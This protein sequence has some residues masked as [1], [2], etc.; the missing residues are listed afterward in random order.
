MKNSISLLLLLFSFAFTNSSFTVPSDDLSVLMEKDRNPP[1]WER[2]GTRKVSFKAER[3]EIMVTGQEGTFRS[4][5]LMVHKAGIN[6]KKMIVHF[7]SG[8]MQDVELRQSIPAG[9]ETR[10]IDLKGNKRIIKKVVFYYDTKNRSARKAT[11]E[12]WGRH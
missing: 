10:V 11:V 4:L 1:R 7:G 12:L 6:I 9:G 3:D 2:L 5:K 8:Q